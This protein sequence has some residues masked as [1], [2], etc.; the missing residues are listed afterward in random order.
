VPTTPGRKIRALPKIRPIV[1]AVHV[2]PEG[3]DMDR[4]VTA[5]WTDGELSRGSVWTRKPDAPR[6]GAISLVAAVLGANPAAAHMHRLFKQFVSPLLNTWSVLF[7]KRHNR[8]LLTYLDVERDPV[9]P[10]LR[11]WMAT[12]DGTPAPPSLRSMT[13]NWCRPTRRRMSRM[14]VRRSPFR[15]GSNP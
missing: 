4:L 3:V 2:K 13:E 10:Q 5:H 14:P 8:A 9:V 11:D 7:P 12:P 1:V 15:R 6:S